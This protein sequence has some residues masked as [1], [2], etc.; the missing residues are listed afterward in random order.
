MIQSASDV[1][2]VVAEPAHVSAADFFYM[3]FS[4][5]KWRPQQKNGKLLRPP[6]VFFERACSFI[7]SAG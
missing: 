3:S 2:T 5:E 7:V 4:A 6:G 1:T